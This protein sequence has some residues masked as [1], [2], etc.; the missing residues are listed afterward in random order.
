MNSLDAYPVDQTEELL[1]RNVSDPE[2]GDLSSCQDIEE[3]A[4]RSK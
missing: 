1:L 4:E 3:F 2:L